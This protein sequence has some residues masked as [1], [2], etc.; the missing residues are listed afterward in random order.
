MVSRPLCITAPRLLVLLELSEFSAV[1]NMAVVACELAQQ[2]RVKLPIHPSTTVP[3]RGMVSQLVVYS[4]SLCSMTC[5][6]YSWCSLQV[7]RDKVSLPGPQSLTDLTLPDWIMLH[8]PSSVVISE[9]S[10]VPAAS[11]EEDVLIVVCWPQTNLV[12]ITAACAQPR[13]A[14]TTSARKAI[15][16]TFCYNELLTGSANRFS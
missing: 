3:A 15:A 11:S 9:N 8:L 16:V 2:L 7:M 6:L 10:A 4:A 13:R 14:R 5:A 1:A 12:C